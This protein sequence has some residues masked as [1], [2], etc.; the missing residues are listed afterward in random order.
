MPIDEKRLVQRQEPSVG[1]GSSTPTLANIRAGF[2]RSFV[3]Q[4][5]GLSMCNVNVGF[6]SALNGLVTTPSTM[7]LI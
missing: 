2:I 1:A 6:V 3:I 4:D 5:H 7:S